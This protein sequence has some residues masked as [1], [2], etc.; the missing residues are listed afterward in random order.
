MESYISINDRN[1]FQKYKEKYCISYEDIEKY[2][3]YKKYENIKLFD[4]FDIKVDAIKQF[5]SRYNTQ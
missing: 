5:F 1:V 4:C 3:V 2:N